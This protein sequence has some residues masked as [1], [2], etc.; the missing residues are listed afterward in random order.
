MNPARGVPPFVIPQP[1]LFNVRVSFTPADL[2]AARRSMA[3]HRTQFSEEAIERAFKATGPVWKGEVPL[4]AMV[5]GA[6]SND[7]FR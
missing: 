3:C 6:A 5:P 4:T 7:L 2:D 1:S